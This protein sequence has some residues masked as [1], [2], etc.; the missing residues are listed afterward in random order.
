MSSSVNKGSSTSTS[1]S[2]GDSSLKSGDVS[3]MK[4]DIIGG[5][6]GTSSML[7]S[8]GKP[9]SQSSSSEQSSSQTT[10]SLT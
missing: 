1:Q 6:G 4:E 10:S 7:G 9:S 8:G 3:K 5:V 2:K